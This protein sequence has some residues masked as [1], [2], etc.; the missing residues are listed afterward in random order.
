[1][2]F[3][4]AFALGV[5]RALVIAPRLG[6]TRAVLIEVPVLV[7][8]S[9]AIARRMRGLPTFSVAQR[10]VMGATAFA[11]TMACEAALA[12]ALRGQTLA[13]WS[14]SLATP[15]GLLGLAGQVAFA[16]MPIL[17]GCRLARKTA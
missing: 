16:A 8:V 5:A 6:E 14:Q 12:Q 10:S 11:L 17:I 4:L 1:M 3:A 7:V 13:A 2:I 15:L 9:W